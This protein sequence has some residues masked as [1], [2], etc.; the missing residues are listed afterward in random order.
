VATHAQPS[1][2]VRALTDLTEAQVRALLAAERRLWAERLSWDMGESLQLAAQA[3]SCGVLPGVA[4]T[5]DARPV[6]YLS[7]HPGGR[8]V[9]LCGAFIGES[10]PACTAELLVEATVESA[11]VAG[12]RVEGQLTVFSHQGALDAA[13]AARGFA[14]VPREYLRLDTERVPR[15]PAS[16]VPRVRA[17]EFGRW[18]LPACARILVRAHAGGVEAAINSAFA[19]ESTA[20]SYLGEIVSGTGCGTLEADASSVAVR[21]RD[22]LG[23]CLATRIGTGSAHVPQVA[24]DP[25][26]QGQGIGNLLLTRTLRLLA[27]RGAQRVTLSV[28]RENVAAARWYAARGFRPVTRFAAYHGLA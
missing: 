6:G 24:V 26:Q 25:A 9:R 23:F 7:H 21:G 4:V 18:A 12:R 20:H 16:E 15:A 1:I 22:V 17:R 13:F 27:E 8:L 3:V 19:E 10:A 2:G 5:V 28:S 11:T 14:V